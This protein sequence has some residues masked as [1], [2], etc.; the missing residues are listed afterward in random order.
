MDDSLLQ[1]KVLG[2]EFKGVSL[3]YDVCVVMLMSR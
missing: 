3:V 2:C 1:A